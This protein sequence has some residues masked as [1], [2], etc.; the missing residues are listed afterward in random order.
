MERTGRRRRKIRFWFG[1]VLEYRGKERGDLYA[2]CSMIGLLA[3][4]EKP[5]WVADRVGMSTGRP[6]YRSREGGLAQ[7]SL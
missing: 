7:T 4:L 6:P 3:C 5:L 2:L 1:V